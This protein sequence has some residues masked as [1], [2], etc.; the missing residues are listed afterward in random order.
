MRKPDIQV[1][2][3]T[4]NYYIPNRYDIADGYINNPFP[5]GYKFVY[6]SFL[7]AQAGF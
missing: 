2:G 5:M 7:L 6:I 1:I 3:L 4:G